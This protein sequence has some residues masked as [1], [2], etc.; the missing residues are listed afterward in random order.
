M[1]V[2]LKEGAAEPTAATIL[3][4]LQ[5]TGALLETLSGEPAMR[6]VLAE[7]DPKVVGAAVSS[8]AKERNVR[9]NDLLKE[10]EWLDHCL[11]HLDL[12]AKIELDVTDDD[13][14][15][16]EVEQGECEETD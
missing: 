12:G 10:L 5:P 4:F 7:A 3:L 11:A 14:G 1:R 2:L 6:G 13:C 8:A 9:P 15:L 16:L